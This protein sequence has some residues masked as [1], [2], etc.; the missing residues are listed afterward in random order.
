L[1]EHNIGEGALKLQLTT[2]REVKITNLDVTDHM[3]YIDK[4][5]P[6]KYGIIFRERLFVANPEVFVTFKLSLF[7][8]A[9]ATGDQ[10]DHKNPPPTNPKDKKAPPAKGTAAA[11]TAL[12][13]P[14]L[15][16]E[17]AKELDTP[18]LLYLELYENDELKQVVAGYNEAVLNSAVLRGDK[19]AGHNY[20]LQARFELREFPQAATLND[21]SQGVYWCL[22][23]SGTDVGSCSPDRRRGQ[24]YPERRKREELDRFLGGQRGWQE[25]EG[26]G[27]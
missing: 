9:T 26:Q 2:S 1:G 6:Y 5:N 24:R 19:L 23:L 21:K 3:E 15:D 16:Y 11:P 4:Y 14:A 25:G 7:K 10:D 27:E 18:R 8:V 17:N 13:A 22:S 12:Q 20:Y